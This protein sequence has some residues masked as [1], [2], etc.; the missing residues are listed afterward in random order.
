MRRI[1]ADGILSGRAV[2]LYTVEKRIYRVVWIRVDLDVRAL[3]PVDSAANDR[4]IGSTRGR[5]NAFSGVEFAVPDINIL[6]KTRRGKSNLPHA[7][8]I[9]RPAQKCPRIIR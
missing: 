8:A 6:V 5:R 3:P 1:V 9:C 2:E 4:W 7:S